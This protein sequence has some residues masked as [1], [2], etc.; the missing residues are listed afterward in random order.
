MVEYS[1]AEVEDI[2]RILELEKQKEFTL[3]AKKAE[4]AKDQWAVSQKVLAEAAMDR[5]LVIAKE[6]GKV[7]GYGFYK[8]NKTKTGREVVIPIINV[9]SA[10]QRAGIGKNLFKLI[11]TR[12]AGKADVLK[13]KHTVG[14]IQSSE[15][16][17][18]KIGMEREGN[19]LIKKRRGRK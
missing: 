11:E 4:E 1:V 18:K 3:V 14:F 17:I 8:Y 6:E 2:E 16:F 9:V 13:A 7:V 19:Y 5:R 12:T 15:G 10:K